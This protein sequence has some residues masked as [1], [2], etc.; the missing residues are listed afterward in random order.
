MEEDFNILELAK[1][2]DEIEVNYF[3]KRIINRFSKLSKKE[4]V[5]QYAKNQYQKQLIKE[6]PILIK[7][8]N[9][10]S[11]KGYNIILPFTKEDILKYDPDFIKDYIEKVR[12]KYDLNNLFIPNKFK[13]Y[14]DTSIE[15]EDDKKVLM[16]MVLDQ[17]MKKIL[18]EHNIEYKSL[19]LVIIDSED[20]RME[21]LLELFLKDLNYLTIITNRVEYFEEIQQKIYDTTGLVIDVTS[22]P[23]K[24]PI[25]GN[26]IIDANKKLNKN[27]NYFDKSA[28]VIDL[29]SNKEKLQ[30][31]YSRRKDLETIYDVV[32]TANSTIVNNEM[33]AYYLKVKSF[34][35]SN[36]VRSN[37]RNYGVVELLKEATCYDIKLLDYISTFSHTH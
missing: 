17:L 15:S 7:E 3:L 24:E 6:L 32:L 16:Y 30:Y 35:F 4:Y 8:F 27:Y 23:V 11:E 19:R 34:V 31:L 12:I 2:K 33:F 36:F 10:L 14:V 37:S 22:N 25:G 1:E 26:V 28:V 29:E 5:K 21:Y 9:Y 20:Y 18:K 13:K